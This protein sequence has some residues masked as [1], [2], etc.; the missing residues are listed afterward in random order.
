M[1]D[2]SRPICPFSVHSCSLTKGGCVTLNRADPKRQ[3]ICVAGTQAVP[4]GWHAVCLYMCVCL[5]VLSV[6][7]LV[8]ARTLSCLC[9][10]SSA[11]VARFVVLFAGDGLKACLVKRR[12]VGRKG[13]PCTCHEG[14]VTS[15]VDL[16]LF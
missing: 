5:S 6:V 8:E 14:G 2:R 13:T 9:F 3:E 15:G 10:F 16:L 11:V 12:S 7:C 4:R 1:G